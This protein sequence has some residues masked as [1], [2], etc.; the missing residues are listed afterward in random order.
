[1]ISVVEQNPSSIQTDV[2]I[3]LHSAPENSGNKSI[4]IRNIASGPLSLFLPA[5]PQIIF[6][7]HLIDVFRLCTRSGGC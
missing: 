4:S 3:T 2:A 5:S 1:M 7:P 6:L